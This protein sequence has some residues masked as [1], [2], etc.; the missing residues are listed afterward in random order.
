MSLSDALDDLEPRPRKGTSPDEAAAARLEMTSTHADVQTGA[1][2]SPIVSVGDWD[3]VLRHF[4]LDPAEFRVVGDSVRMSRWQQSKGLEDGTRSTIW[5]HS[6]SARFQRVS[7]AV[8]ESD[9][10]A[11]R[12]RVQSWRPAKRKA[13]SALGAPSTLFVD[14]GD[15]QLGKA[16]TMSEVV[17]AIEES[18]DKTIQRVKELRR[19]GRNLASLSIWNMGDVVEAVTGNY[20]SQSFTTE[21]NRRQQGNLALDL[22]TAGLRA[23]A[24]LFDDVEFGSLLCNHGENR[25]GGQKIAGDSDNESGYLADTLRRVMADRP[26]FDHVRWSIPHD[27]MVVGATMSGVPVGL[28]HAHTAPTQQARKVEWLRAQSDRLLRT[29][30]VDPRLWLTAHMHHLSVLDCGPFHW[31]QTPARDAGSKWWTDASGLWST[32]G[33]LTCLVGEHDEAGGA[34]AGS[35]RGWSDLAVL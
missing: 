26:G 16:G 33:T 1:V 28:S 4:G 15:W 27:E 29:K 6:Y 12:Q 14:W 3:G 34:L 7:G 11:L 24:P 30:G 31:I 20:S 22:W 5:L 25:Q 35:G 21:L 23:L 32:P 19:A 18:F 9:V 10:E 2:A 13:P 17:P 8:A